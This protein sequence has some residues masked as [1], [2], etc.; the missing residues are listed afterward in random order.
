MLKFKII[1]AGAAGN[2]AAVELIERGFNKDD[3]FLIN[4]TR[5]DIPEEYQNSSIIFGETMGN[6]GG[7]GK[8]RD[9]A[10]KLFMNDLKSGKI[11]IDTIPDP[12][13]NAIIIVSSTEGGTGSGITPILSKYITEVLGLHVIVCLFFGFETDIRGMKNS[14]D[15]IKSLDEN[16][17]IGIIGIRNNGFSKE[18][19]N[20]RACE[21]M[22]NSY[23]CDI[24]EILSGRLIRP[25]DQNIDDTDLLKLVTTPGY[26]YVGKSDIS[27]IKNRSQ[28]NETIS[29]SLDN[30]PLLSS[31][32][33]VRRMGLFF[34][35]NPALDDHIDT[36]GC[37]IQDEY[38]IPYEL[39][40]HVQNVE[41]REPSSMFWIASGL[42][43]PVDAIKDIA[44]DY[45][46]Q[47]QESKKNKTI[48]D[49][50]EIDTDDDDEYNMLNKRTSVKD[51]NN[52]FSSFEK[53]SAKKGVEA[54]Y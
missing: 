38:G 45:K 24:V 7:C 21:Q 43:V 5:K 19:A 14:I 51:K 9:T 39:F 22:A 23:F 25:S 28:F 34:K 36:T 27:K 10:N 17:N 30:S 31:N 37:M 46:E 48:F 4:S 18:T 20:L 53:G 35:I 11:A 47:V 29:D 1:G 42:P 32:K 54:E 40:T 13:T 16:T 41:D 50:D 15:L 52:F 6:L 3:V 44:D 49:L 26:M 33:G 8:E 12:D 2:K